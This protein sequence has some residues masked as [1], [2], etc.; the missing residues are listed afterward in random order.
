MR[1]L[2]LIAALTGL[3]LPAF[4]DDAALLMGVSR[5]DEFRRVSNGVEVLNS[6]DDLRAAGYAVSTLSNGSAN[7]M[8]RLLNRFAA[9]ATDAERLI[10][11]LAGRFVTDGTRSWFLAADSDR[12]SPF[13]L[14]EAVSIEMVMHVL[15]QAPGQAI[16]ILGYDQ[17]ADNEIGSYLRQGVGRLDVPQGVTVLFGPPN[18]TDGVVMQAVTEPGADVMAFVRD[19][20]RLNAT[21]YTPQS[22]IMQ[23]ADA[24]REP[25]LPTIEPSLRAWTL[26]QDRDTAQAYRDFIFDNPDSPYVTEARRKLDQI[27]RDPVRL[28]EIEEERLNLTRNQRRAIQRNLTLMEFNTR[29]VDGIFGPGSRGAIRNW[30]QDNGFAQTSFLTTEQINRIDAQARRLAAEAEAEEERAR[31]EARALDRDYWEETGARG[32]VAGYRAYLERYPEGIFADQA[33]ER[34]AAT[35]E[36]NNDEARAREQALNINPVLRRL[37]ENRL[38]QLGY[39]PGRVDG[40]FDNNTRRAI[41]RYQRDGSLTATGYL[42]QATLAR[43]LADTFG[44]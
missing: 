17:D 2:P 28:A 16:L 34:L 7:D 43:L 24:E 3:A 38:E 22:L 18:V 5:Y 12:P 27:E 9:E 37:I 4:A 19:S 35:Q 41:A 39:N 15:A 13:G 14:D 26:A 40:R 30:Q 6:A 25:S 11:G 21:G 36:E 10:V 1:K 31:E 29:G 32:T 33:R 42:D 20:R 23:S 44:R 8:D